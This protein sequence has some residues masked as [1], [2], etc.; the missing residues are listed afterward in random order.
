MEGKGEVLLEFKMDCQGVYICVVPGVFIAT[1]LPN[2]QTKDE[3]FY[4]VLMGILLCMAWLR[5][6]SPS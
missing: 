5:F 1:Q 4:V 6:R 3:G 2:Q